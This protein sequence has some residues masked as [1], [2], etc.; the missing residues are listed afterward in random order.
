[1]ER[2]PFSYFHFHAFINVCILTLS[3]SNFSSFPASADAPSATAFYEH[4]LFWLGRSQ[5]AYRLLSEAVFPPISSWVR[6]S[7]DSRTFNSWQIDDIRTFLYPVA[8]WGETETDLLTCEAILLCGYGNYYNPCDVA[9]AVFVQQPQELFSM[10]VQR[11][12]RTEA[13][14]SKGPQILMTTEHVSLAKKG[15]DYINTKYLIWPY[16]L[17]EAATDT[18]V[19]QGISLIELSPENALRPFPNSA[20]T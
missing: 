6:G 1:M 2:S 5:H 15:R 11:V 12:R 19:K 20:Q 18:L 17:S 4:A 7:V 8:A 14:V 10:L 3:E 9:I 16:S 13:I